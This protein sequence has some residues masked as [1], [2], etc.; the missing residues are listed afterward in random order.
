MISQVSCTQAGSVKYTCTGCGN[1]Y[2][3][4][5]NATGHDWVEATCTQAKHCTNCNLTEGSALGHTTTNGKCERCGESISIA[6]KCRLTVRN[7]LPCTI[8]SY[9]T[10]TGNFR[11]QVRLEN[12]TY[13]FSANQDGT[14]DLKVSISVYVIATGHVG[15]AA[16][17]IKIYDSNGRLIGAENAQKTNAVAGLYFSTAEYF[18][19]LVP[20]NYFVE[21]VP[22]F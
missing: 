1:T 19:D 13:T 16:L 20:G 11:S 18:R 5:Q 7:T 12:V 2:T 15:D 8:T 4:T 3:E 6:D 17:G 21:F 10:S 14:V 9:Y 22:A